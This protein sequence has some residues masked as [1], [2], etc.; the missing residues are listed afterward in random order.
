MQGEGGCPLAPYSPYTHTLLSSAAI[1]TLPPSPRKLHPPWLPL[2]MRRD[3]V[4]LL[5]MY[6]LNSS[7]AARYVLP[8]EVHVS[9]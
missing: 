7:T 1:P 5:P 3:V 8:G 9:A 6:C 4:L 2:A